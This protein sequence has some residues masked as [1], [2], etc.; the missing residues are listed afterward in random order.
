MCGHRN[1]NHHAAL[2]NRMAETLGIDMTK[3]LHD[4]RLSAEEW[5]DTVLRCTG[6]SA[7]ETC[8]D[9]LAD[10][11]E[12]GAEATP[13]YCRNTALMEALRLPPAEAAE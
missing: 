4:E 2:V 12:A 13:D 1:L 9:W 10:H 5:R 6:C 11:H 3:A 8:Q 7:P